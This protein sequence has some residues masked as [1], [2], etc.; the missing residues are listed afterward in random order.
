M[1]S[2]PQG[3][4]INVYDTGWAMNNWYGNNWGW[5]GGFGW[6]MN[7][8]YGN[9]WGMNNWGWNG[10][11][12]WGMNFGFGLNNFGWNNWYGN[13]WYGNNWGI[14]ITITIA[15]TPTTQVE[16]GPQIQI[17][18]IHRSYNSTSRTFSNDRSSSNSRT[19]RETGVTLIGA[20]ILSI[21]EEVAIEKERTAPLIEVIQIKTN[22]ITLLE[23]EPIQIILEEETPLQQ[24]RILLHLVA[25]ETKAIRL[26]DRVLIVQEMKATL[27]ADRA[28]QVLVA[29]DHHKAA[30]EGGQ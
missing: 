23:R 20:Q 19:F 15:S 22:R 16:E 21:L 4:S 18:Q 13:N 11:Y 17:L 30:Q 5:N 12:G 25:L 1:G 26:T 8:W 10:N 28:L 24:D 7:N 3:V 27:P 2:N 6:G 29:V 14:P 9:N